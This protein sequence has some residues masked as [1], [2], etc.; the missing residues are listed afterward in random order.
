MTN[1][2]SIGAVFTPIHW[3]KFAIKTFGLLEKWLAGRSIF[4]PTMGEG[5]LLLSLIDA[6]LEQGHALADLP[7]QNLY[8]V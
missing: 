5:N 7:T 8:G 2:L 1:T 3:A 6:G 4:A